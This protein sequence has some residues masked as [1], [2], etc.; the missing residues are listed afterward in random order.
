[1]DLDTMVFI[2]VQGEWL[3]AQIMGRRGS[4]YLVEIYREGG[5][6]KQSDPKYQY[7][8]HENDI[9]LFTRDTWREHGNYTKMYTALCDYKAA[10]GLLPACR[11]R[12]MNF[13]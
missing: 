6:N 8:R 9:K 7:W 4:K 3:P 2:S 11:M 12:A 5:N 13:F 1:M 10:G